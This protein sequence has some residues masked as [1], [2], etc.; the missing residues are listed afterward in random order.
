MSVYVMSDIHGLS[1]RYMKMLEKISLK[2]EDTRVFDS[3]KKEDIQM[4]A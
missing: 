2:E 3:W 1:D 4:C